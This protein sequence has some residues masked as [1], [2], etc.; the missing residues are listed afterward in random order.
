V[1]WNSCNECSAAGLY[2][3]FVMRIV[4]AEDASRPVRRRENEA[5]GARGLH[6]NPVGLF[7]RGARR[8]F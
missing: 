6:S 3:S 8:V 5:G 7:Y 2:T 4:A 1:L